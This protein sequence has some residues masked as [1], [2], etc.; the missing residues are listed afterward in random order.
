MRDIDQVAWLHII[1]QYR[2][3]DEAFITGSVAGLTALRE[4][5]ERAIATGD[6][7][8]EAYARDGEGYGVVV[9][10]TT[11]MAGLGKP[12]YLHAEALEMARWE[13][14]HWEQMIRD[15]RKQR[16]ATMRAGDSARQCRAIEALRKAGLR[17]N[18][19]AILA[20]LAFAD[21]EIAGKDAR[22]E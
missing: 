8:A 17:T 15:N 21:A 4:A 16:L 2:Q 3:H 14:D 10:R 18:D 19:A 7:E 6:G 13:S 1:G 22:D 12:V 20:M 11:T 5:I 9:R